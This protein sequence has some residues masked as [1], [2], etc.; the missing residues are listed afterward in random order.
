MWRTC[1]VECE[2]LRTEKGFM[3][4]S[5]TAIR[6]FWF[7]ASKV[8]LTTPTYFQAGLS[9]AVFIPISPLL[10][11]PFSQSECRFKSSAIVGKLYMRFNSGLRGKCLTTFMAVFLNLLGIFFSHNQDTI[12]DPCGHLKIVHILTDTHILYCM[13]DQVPVT[14]SLQ[15]NGF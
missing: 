7:C 10:L 1:Q 4:S 14:S 6:T 5:D 8:G 9:M 2:V 11:T 3:P 15:Y 13:I 12:L